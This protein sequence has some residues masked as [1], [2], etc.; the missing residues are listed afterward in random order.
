MRATSHKVA[1]I[2]EFILFA[3]QNYKCFFFCFF[4]IYFL[5][6]LNKKYSVDWTK[7]VEEVF[8]YLTAVEMAIP[9][10]KITLLEEK[11]FKNVY[12]YD[13]SRSRVSIKIK[14]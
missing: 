2:P 9:L 8:R 4:F 6:W 13:L 14:L 1:Y 5:S 12:K 10:D 3:M 7:V 11:D